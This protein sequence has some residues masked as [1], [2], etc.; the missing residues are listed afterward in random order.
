MVDGRW[1]CTL[2][3]HDVR[4][5]LLESHAL[6]PGRMVTRRERV[7]YYCSNPDCANRI[8]PKRLGWA[9]PAGGGV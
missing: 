1:V 2:C 4:Y 8:P 9:R 3:G 6:R 5:R 7:P